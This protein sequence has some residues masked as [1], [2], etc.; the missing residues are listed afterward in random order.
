MPTG[1]AKVYSA[2]TEPEDNNRNNAKRSNIV[3]QTVGM[4]KH[5]VTKVLSG[6]F[7]AMKKG[8]DSIEKDA[9]VATNKL[10]G[11]AKG[12]AKGD[13]KSA[14]SALKSADDAQLP[15]TL[16]HQYFSVE[17][18]PGEW[19]DM[20]AAIIHPNS[21]FM[22]VWNVVMT[23]FILFCVL[24]IPFEMSFNFDAANWADPPPFILF[25]N[26]F[27]LAMD[28]YFLVDMFVQFRV[29]LLVD[30]EL[31]QH[32][33]RIAKNYLLGWFTPDFVSTMGSLL[34]RILAGVKG[35][36]LLR[37]VKVIR[38]I[39]LLKLLRMAK[40]KKVLDSISEGVG[41]EMAVIA[42]L[43]KL[44]LITLFITHFCGCIFVSLAGAA[45]QDSCYPKDEGEVRLIS[46]VDFENGWCTDDGKTN[47]DLFPE[48]GSPYACRPNWI[49]SYHSENSGHSCDPDT[50]ECVPTAYPNVNDYIQ[51]NSA[52]VYLTS[53][54][55]AFITV[56]T[57]GYGDILPV[58]NDEMTFC[59]VTAFV[60]TGIFAFINGEITALASQKHAS[61]AAY[62]QKK[63]SVND[64]MI[65]YNLPKALR[66]KIR[67]FYQRGYEQG[68]FLDTDTVVSELPLDLRGEVRDFLKKDLIHQVDIFRHAPESVCAYLV[69]EFQSMEYDVED[70]IFEQGTNCDE[71]VMLDHG[72]VELQIFKNGVPGEILLVGPGT[73]FGMHHQDTSV[74]D[75]VRTQQVNDGSDRWL[76]TSTATAV[77]H[78]EV[79]KISLEVVMEL[80]RL[81]PEFEDIMDHASGQLHR[82]TRRVAIEAGEE[83]EETKAAE[84]PIAPSTPTSRSSGGEGEGETELETVG[85]VF[86]TATKS[87]KMAAKLI[88]ASKSPAGGGSTNSPAKKSMAKIT[89]AK[90]AAKA[91]RQAARERL[92]TNGGHPADL[93]SN[94]KGRWVSLLGVMNKAEDDP[95][96]T[97]GNQNGPG[98][99]GS[100]GGGPGG[101]NGGGASVEQVQAVHARMDSLEKTLGNV[102]DR[103][104]SMEKMLSDFKGD[105]VTAIQ[106]SKSVSGSSG[107]GES[108]A[109]LEAEAGACDGDLVI[110]PIMS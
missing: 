74:V 81:W 61:S 36:S 78:C 98:K 30:G 69:N 62:M 15:P 90:A 14:L 22:T 83:E 104:E 109:V 3:S 18:Y 10:T 8:V 57:V 40:L 7:N 84:G 51:Q 50:G 37:N 21:T 102:Q 35:L 110:T 87:F 85:S 95:R 49:Q 75:I 80:T 60:G 96:G 53:L 11:V 31:D 48:P 73:S 5:T 4:G 68:L 106:Q 65:Y 12:V 77:Q 32:G 23:V 76:Y 91:R 94:A 17:R 92:A 52:T 28:I 47:L 45:C 2:D 44:M 58:N 70:Y 63:D 9:V 27:Q 41:P 71:I 20:N 64:F 29:A 88:S 16:Y 100:N 59:L 72:T 33:C 103:F 66:V 67:G 38:L 105:I 99:A 82:I 39:R 43:G 97:G 42:K 86:G 25:I 56:T 55:W 46:N 1:K 101:P 79:F 54:Y 34:S 19:I 13:L 24:W 93:H 108:T 107:R 89:M 26:G 6:G